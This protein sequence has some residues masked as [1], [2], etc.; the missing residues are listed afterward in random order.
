MRDH[1]TD[2]SRAGSVVLLHTLG[3]GSSHL[4]WMIERMGVDDEYRLVTFRVSARPD[5]TGEP[6]RGVRI[7]DHR[8]AYLEHE[9]PTRG[10]DGR[11]ERLARGVVRSLEIG[12]ARIVCTIV[13]DDG[14]V[15]CVGRRDP[16]GDVADGEGWV[17]ERREGLAL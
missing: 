17:F 11:V 9:G 16:S 8:A 3:D 14:A 15:S 4:D 13:W 12:E 5:G 1:H 2:Q 10:G 7:G 6:F